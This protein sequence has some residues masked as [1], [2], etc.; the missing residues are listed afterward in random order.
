MSDYTREG[1]ARDL[2]TMEASQDATERNAAGILAIA[3]AACLG[4]AE[5]KHVREYVMES[6]KAFELRRSGMCGKA[7]ECEAAADYR[8]SE[9]RKLGIAW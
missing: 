6:K 2:A 3:A 4:A 7:I 9:L 1:I 8:V 5:H